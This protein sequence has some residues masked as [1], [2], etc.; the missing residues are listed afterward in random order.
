MQ[1]WYIG[2]NIFFVLSG[3]LI[4]TRYLHQLNVNTTWFWGYLRN[5]FARIYPVYFLL[6]VFTFAVMIVR[7]VNNYYEWP[8]S[9]SVMDK[10]AVIFLNLTLT[11]AFFHELTLIGVPTAWTLTIEE[12]F[13]VCAPFLILGLKRNFRWIYLYPLLLFATGIALVAFCSR[14]LPYYGLMA[15]LTVMFGNTFFGR[16]VEFLTGMALAH[17]LARS[18]YPQPYLSRIKAT[19]LGCSGLVLGTASMAII[20]YS[21]SA[22]SLAYTIILDLVRNILL[23]LPIALLLWGLITEQTWLQQILQTKAFDLLGKSSYAFY[24]LHLGAVDLIFSHFVTGHWVARLVSYY[25]LSIVL[26]KCF[27]HPLNKWLRYQPHPSQ[28]QKSLVH[29]SL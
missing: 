17:W 5:R 15:N 20:E 2:V 23:P 9:F 19:W 11:R 10:A 22:Q 6:T 4:T 8:A 26:Y 27:E 28:K 21:L 18:G 7:P 14:Y 12:T 16:C 24:L 25:L 29:H 3:F 1:Q 13:Y